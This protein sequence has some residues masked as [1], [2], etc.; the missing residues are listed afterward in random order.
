MS[1]VLPEINNSSSLRTPSPKIDNVFQ[2]R[3]MGVKMMYMEE[4]EEEEEFTLEKLEMIGRIMEEGLD[5]Q[6]R[7]ISYKIVLKITS[8]FS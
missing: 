6:V 5:I 8:K 3:Y 2:F 1:Y 4:E 7:S